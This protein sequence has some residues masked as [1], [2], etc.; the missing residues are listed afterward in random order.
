MIDMQ[1]GGRGLLVHMAVQAVNDVSNGPLVGV[2]NDHGNRGASGGLR[3]DV[4]VGVVTGGATTEMGCQDIRP[5]LDR[6]AVR[7]GLGAGLGAVVCEVNHY[8]MLDAAGGAVVMG[9]EIVRMA[10]DALA[11]MD[12][13]ALFRG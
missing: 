11:D 3:V 4:A 1:M 2:G 9:G 6:V 12:I 5:V 13:R 7:A 8:I 10:I